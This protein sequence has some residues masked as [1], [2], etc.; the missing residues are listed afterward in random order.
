MLAIPT[1]SLVIKQ[2]EQGLSSQSH[3][4]RETVRKITTNKCVKCWI[5]ATR[6]CPINKR[7]RPTSERDIF[8]QSK[9]GGGARVLGFVLGLL[10]IGVTYY[11]ATD[12]F[13]PPETQQVDVHEKSP[14]L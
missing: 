4:E 1:P 5:G 3:Q 9:T 14:Q 6:A 12:S 10:A 2:R 11:L 7:R 8:R 13:K